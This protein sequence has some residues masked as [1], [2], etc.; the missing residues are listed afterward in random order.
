MAHPCESQVARNPSPVTVH[1]AAP[2]RLGQ[3]PD[4]LI[5]RPKQAPPRTIAAWV[6]G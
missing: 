5:V 2:M 1:L 6:R 4:I 3:T